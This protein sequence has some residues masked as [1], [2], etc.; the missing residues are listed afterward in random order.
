MWDGTSS[1]S[2]SG[3]S[4]IA[5]NQD[6]GCLEATSIASIEALA[7]EQVEAADELLGVGERPVADQR[8]AVADAHGLGGR[9]RVQRLAGDVDARARSVSSTQARLCS[10]MTAFSSA[11]R[12]VLDADQL[13]VLHRA[14][15]RG[16]AFMPVRRTQMRRMDSL[17]EA[18]RS[19]R[20][21][22]VAHLCGRWR[23]R[24]GLGAE[25]G[26]AQTHAH[27]VAPR[28]GVGEDGSCAPGRCAGRS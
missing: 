17:S 27:V 21:R 22:E 4:S 7:I 6:T 24:C 18:E 5:L 26:E 25:A 9:R 2:S 14:H 12:L 13:Q 28:L 8:L 11:V 19:E 1:P 16:F 10:R 3:R 20:R 23:L 15:L